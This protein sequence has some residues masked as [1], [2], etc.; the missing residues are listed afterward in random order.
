MFLRRKNIAAS[1]DEELIDAI[2]KG[3]R[4][5][6]GGLWDRYAHL[7]Y[8]VGMKYLKN[9]EKAKD[10]VLELFADLPEILKKH[11]VVKFRP[12]IHT[13]MRN[14]CLIELRKVKNNVPIE[15]QPVAIDN[16]AEIELHE[17]DLRSLEKAIEEL[18]AHQRTCITLFHLQ[19]HSYKEISAVTGL[20]VDSVR[21]NIQNG[22]RNLRIMIQRN[23]QRNK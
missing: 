8:G 17:Q 3:D 18:D 22:R 21:S 1:N 16:A 2:G 4:E 19:R 20:S 5:A 10:L 6:L 11:D 7:L 14:R 13:V 9:T 15:E 23:D 12:W